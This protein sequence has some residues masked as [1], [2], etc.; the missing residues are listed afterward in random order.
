MLV[1]LNG[2]SVLRRRTVIDGEPEAPAFVRKNAC[3]TVCPD[4]T[5][6]KLKAPFVIRPPVIARFPEPFPKP[7]A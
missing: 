5:W 7:S 1:A 3:E 4:V 6:P 2:G